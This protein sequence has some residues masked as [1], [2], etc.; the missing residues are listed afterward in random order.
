M[1]TKPLKT[2]EFNDGAY[3]ILHKVCK[4]GSEERA[5]KEEINGYV[6]LFFIS[7]NA[8]LKTPSDLVSLE[9]FDLVVIPPKESFTFIVGD[10]VDSEYYTISTTEDM[11]QGVLKDDFI[12]G[13]S[14]INL[15]NYGVAKSCFDRLNHYEKTKENIDSVYYEK[16]LRFIIAE[17]YI[18][19]STIKK[20]EP[21]AQSSQANP[22]LAR[23]ISY[24]NSHL[25][26]VSVKNLATNFKV[27]TTYIYKV[28]KKT[29]GV[30]PKEY[31][32]NKRLSY[33]KYLIENGETAWNTAFQCGYNDYSS[34]YRAYHK[35]F[36]T[37]PSENPPEEESKNK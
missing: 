28:L 22:F 25:Q 16:L 33:A 29:L 27:S 4:G 12:E 30:S 35:F 5:E 13:A 34:F 20:T 15:T 18:N 9:A 7:G 23:V 21:N 31:I 19:L 32:T 11:V 1:R 10:D 8:F 3:K 36:N 6:I 2:Y 24:I 26:T 17:L 14:V 37:T